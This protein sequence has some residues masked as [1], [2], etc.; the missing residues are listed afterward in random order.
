M[1]NESN[2]NTG[3]E[4]NAEKYTWENMFRE[5]LRFRSI[6]PK[7]T[8]PAKIE[9]KPNPLYNWLKEQRKNKNKLS[10]SR[11]EKLSLAG[12]S[13][14]TD[15][16]K[17]SWEEY[18]EAFVE[19]RKANPSGMP[20]AKVTGLTN[21][22]YAWCA[23]Q[24]KNKNKLT[25]LQIEK[26]DNA[27]FVWESEY[28]FSEEVWERNFREFA[29]FKAENPDSMPPY[30]KD[31]MF[32]PL[33]AWC[34]IQKLHKQKLSPERIERLTQT[35]FDWAGNTSSQAMKKLIQQKFSWVNKGISPAWERRYEE[36]LEYRKT[37]PEG[38][39]K[40][41]INGNPSSL[42]QWCIDQI[43]NRLNF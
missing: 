23:R 10:D 20:P 5:F 19:F 24:K 9:G 12:I 3:E 6:N 31:D 16:K 36:L 21:P 43:N 8:P 14:R 13:W 38:T 34:S 32:N 28:S 37:Y 2:K 4:N 7:G 40:R 15:F 22:L 41:I 33:H 39:P 25:P 30:E 18:Y 11:V 35:G 1:E 29:R 27:G 42:Q 17:F 26:L